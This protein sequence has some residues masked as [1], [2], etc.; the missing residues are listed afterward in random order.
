MTDTTTDTTTPPAPPATGTPPADV[1]PERF[2]QLEAMVSELGNLLRGLT[3]SG[4]GDG[5]GSAATGAA[6]PP[7]VPTDR[8]S[9]RDVVRSMLADDD[10]ENRIASMA[11][12]LE[13]LR[14]AVA[15]KLAPPK[16]GWG[17]WI[18]G[19]R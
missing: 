4:G 2:T 7:P 19:S 14:T 11:A 12:E 3:D 6:S 18:V 13:E 15:D 10:R 9:I 8:G 16:R 1:T 17:S 5:N